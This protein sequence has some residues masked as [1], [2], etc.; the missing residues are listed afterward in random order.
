M[1]INEVIDKMT[2]QQYKE[3]VD[4]CT[5]V[6]KIFMGIAR[7][8]GASIYTSEMC[9]EGYTFG[10]EADDARTQNDPSHRRLE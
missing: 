7:D 4:S 2:D 9:P 8:G 6:E 3:L 5:P 1:F 10:K